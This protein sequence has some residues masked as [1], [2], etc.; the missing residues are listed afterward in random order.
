MQ[1]KRRVSVAVIVVALFCFLMYYVEQKNIIINQSQTITLGRTADYHEKSRLHHQ[2]SVVSL[3]RLLRV[4]E[5]LTKEVDIIKKSLVRNENAVNTAS[6]KK[7]IYIDILNKGDQKS[8]NNLTLLVMISSHASHADRRRVI[9]SNWASET[10]WKSYLQER[11]VSF[12]LLFLIG[13]AKNKTMSDN[14]LKESK[15]FGDIL[16]EKLEESFYSLSYKIMIGFQ[17]IHEKCSFDY[18]LKGDDDI[19][20]NIHT[21][22]SFFNKSYL[23]RKELYIGH[24]MSVSGVMRNGRYGVS[25]TEYLRDY[26]PRYCSGGG[27]IMSRDVVKEIIPHYD[28][29]KPLKIDDAY[30]GQLVLKA[31]IDAWHDSRF[32]MYENNCT[33]INDT[34]IA[35]IWRNK[36]VEPSCAKYL[37]EQALQASQK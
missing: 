21:L 31:G 19:F 9:R 8:C 4:I 2:D 28:W 5:G 11:G 20:V 13:D 17:W 1:I 22:M 36:A 26:Y 18:V 3:K 34:I 33:Y 16:I 27:F 24:M 29:I 35:H 37:N 6:N 7:D 30:V 15:I 14:L 10:L 12:G 25:R 32:R 23:P